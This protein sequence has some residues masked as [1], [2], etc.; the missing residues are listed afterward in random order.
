MA[1]QTGPQ[2]KP[3]TDRAAKGTGLAISHKMQII[4]I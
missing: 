1:R 4:P 3:L 2:K